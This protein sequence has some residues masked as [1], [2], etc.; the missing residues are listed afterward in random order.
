MSRRLPM[1]AWPVIVLGSAVGLAYLLPLG[2]ALDPLS[3]SLRVR[4]TPPVWDEDGLAGYLLG[5]D[6]LGRDLF[7]RMLFGLR[8]SLEIGVAAATAGAMI[9]VVLGLLAGF[10]D[11]FLQCRHA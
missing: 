2:M 1:R 10:F 8:T 11:Q 6:H 5:T 4:L 9:G 7:T 3:Q